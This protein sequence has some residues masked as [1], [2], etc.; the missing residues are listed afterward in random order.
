MT[1]NKKIRKLSKKQHTA[2]AALTAAVDEFIDLQNRT[3]HPAGTFD[4]ARRF[5][6]AETFDCCSG[7]RTPSR[8]FPFSLMVHARTAAHVA[9][10]YKVDPAELRKL[11]KILSK[12]EESLNLSEEKTSY[13]IVKN[14]L[15]AKE[16]EEFSIKFRY[17][18]IFK[19]A[20]QMTLD[21]GD[22]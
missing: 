12:N 1:T 18:Q 10:Q 13:K 20:A 21:K 19:F 6:P 5:Y 8:S 22:K 2:A 9:N 3:V 11:K 15:N 16:F 17:D 14:T 4:N 7:I